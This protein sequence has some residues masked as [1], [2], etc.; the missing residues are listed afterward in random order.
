MSSA[1]WQCTPCSASSHRLCQLHQRQSHSALRSQRWTDHTVH[2]AQC[3]QCTAHSAQCTQCTV[4]KARWPLKC[5]GRLRQPSCASS[6]LSKLVWW[7]QQQAGSSLAAAGW[8]LGT[9]GKYSDSPQVSRDGSAVAAAFL[10]YVGHCRAV[11]AILPEAGHSSILLL[12]ELVTFSP[13]FH[14]FTGRGKDQL[15][16]PPYYRGDVVR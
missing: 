15:V 4:H 16:R 12:G 7:Q 8:H 11:L 14:C 2:S 1:L 10:R 9:D 13:L 6:L 5:L 3:T